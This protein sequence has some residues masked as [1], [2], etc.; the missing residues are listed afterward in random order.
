MGNYI[1]VPLGTGLGFVRIFFLPDSD[2]VFRIEYFPAGA[3]IPTLVIE[4]QTI[5]A[6]SNANGAIAL[7]W[8]ILGLPGTP[9]T[10]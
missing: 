3:T 10:I 2:T 7:V 1:D 5:G 9:P 4:G 6:Y 8:L